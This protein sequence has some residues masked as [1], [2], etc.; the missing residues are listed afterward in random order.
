[1]SQFFGPKFW[2][3]QLLVGKTSEVCFSTYFANPNQ[4]LKKS[5]LYGH[6]L[7][8][9]QISGLC[10]STTVG[11]IRNVTDQQKV[12]HMTQIELSK[13]QK[14]YLFQVQYYIHVIRTPLQSRHS[15]V[16][17]RPMIS[18]NC[19]FRS[20]LYVVQKYLPEYPDPP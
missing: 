3:H 15:N 17:G 6:Y 7:P 12:P 10:L 9:Y 8:R 13:L 18:V 11:T 2:P 14:S 5:Q 20:T 4:N 19:Q 1:M 16:H